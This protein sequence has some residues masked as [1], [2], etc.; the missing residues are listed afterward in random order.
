MFIQPKEGYHYVTFSFEF[1]NISSSDAYV[2][3]FSFDCYADG[4]ACDSTYFRDDDLGSATLSPG[5][6]VKG[7]VTF[8]VPDN[9]SV[10][11]V[12]YDEISV[13]GSRIVFSYV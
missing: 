13:F 7:T 8:E 6:K 5:R 2:S 9:A 1:E 11:E 4:A 12:E 3:S 10:V